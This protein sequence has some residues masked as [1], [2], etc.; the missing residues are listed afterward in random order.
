MIGDEIKDEQHHNRYKAKK[1][2]KEYINKN[3]KLLEIF[4]NFIADL[5]VK[6][7]LNSKKG[8]D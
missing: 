4:E 1:E 5:A 2:H 3:R 7:S 8:V 6:D